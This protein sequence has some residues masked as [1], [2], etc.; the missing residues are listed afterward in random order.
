MELLRADR[1]ISCRG[2][3]WR[4]AWSITIWKAGDWERERIEGKAQS[5]P[6]PDLFSPLPP[7][8]IVFW[9]GTKLFPPRIFPDFSP[10]FFLP[11]TRIKDTLAKKPLFVPRL[12]NNK[13]AIF[14]QLQNKT[15]CSIKEILSGH[16]TIFSSKGTKASFTLPLD[17]KAET[18]TR[19]TRITYHFFPV[20]FFFFFLDTVSP[21]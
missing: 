10:L 11:L 12:F 13:V 9:T 16:E 7:R 3:K 15:M 21:H 1:T 2:E 20:L 19:V 18:F 8:S 4:I 5:S 6:F 17:V 14:L